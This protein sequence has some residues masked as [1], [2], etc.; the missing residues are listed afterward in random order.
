MEFRTLEEIEPFKKQIMIWHIV[1]WFVIFGLGAIWHF[2]FVWSG[3]WAPIG[4]LFAVNESVWEHLKIMYWPALIYYAIEG[5]FLYK[6][7]NNFVLAKAITVYLTP[8]L[9]FSIFY[10][11]YGAFGYENFILDTVILFF[12]TGLQQFVSYKLLT[13][14]IIPAEKKYQQPLFIGAIVD[15]AILAILLIVFTYAPIHIQLFEHSFASETGLYGI[16]PSY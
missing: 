6:K 4:W 10:F 2:A 1:G 7:T 9:S 14:E 12:L 5:I 11:I 15:I 3:A 8:I 13:R 16:L